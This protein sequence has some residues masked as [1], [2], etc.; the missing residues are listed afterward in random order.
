MS[1]RPGG[2]KR[3]N[4]TDRRRRKLWMLMTWGDGLKC[5]C[6]HCGAILDF[7]TVESD[8]IVPGGS[9][10]RNNI[11]PACRLCNLTRSNK[12]DWS[13]SLAAAG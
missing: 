5:P 10:C 6:V 11:Q 3:G 13:P 9:Y 7:G 1:A 12:L 8:R 4:S 2:E